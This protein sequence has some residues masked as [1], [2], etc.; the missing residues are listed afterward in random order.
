MIIKRQQRPHTFLPRTGQDCLGDDISSESTSSDDEDDDDSLIWSSDASSYGGYSSGDATSED[1]QPHVRNIINRGCKD[2]RE[3][4]DSFRA[5]QANRELH[6]N[7]SAAPPSRFWE[8]LSTLF[9]RQDTSQPAEGSIGTHAN[10][11][12]R[13]D[14]TD[15]RE[16]SDS[17]QHRELQKQSDVENLETSSKTAIGI[18]TDTLQQAREHVDKY[19]KDIIWEDRKDTSEELDSFPDPPAECEYQ[20]QSAEGN[21]D[22]SSKMDIDII[23]EK[24]QETKKRI[25]TSSKSALDVISERLQRTRE[26]LMKLRAS[27]QEAEK[28]WHQNKKPTTSQISQ[29]T[30]ATFT[31][32]IKGSESTTSS[33]RNVQSPISSK[34]PEILQRTR[35]RLMQVRASR[36]KIENQR[37]KNR[38]G[39][40]QQQ[41]Q[42]EPFDEVLLETTNASEGMMA[43]ELNM[44]NRKKLPRKNA[45]I[46]RGLKTERVRQIHDRLNQIREERAM[47]ETKRTADQE[48]LKK[49]TIESEARKNEDT[50]RQIQERLQRL[51]EQRDKAEVERRNRPKAAEGKLGRI[52]C[53]RDEVVLFTSS[54]GYTQKCN[55]TDTVIIERAVDAAEKRDQVTKKLR[56]AEERLRFLQSDQFQ[57]TMLQIRSNQSRET[58]SFY[59]NDSQPSLCE[60]H[61]ITVRRR[62]TAQVL[63]TLRTE[64][65]ALYDI[66]H[67]IS[68]EEMI[69]PNGGISGSAR[70][71]ARNQVGK[72]YL[73]VMRIDATGMVNC[74]T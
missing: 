63:E 71:Q 44:Q 1:E 18:I 65:I 54:G 24:L 51:R 29:K 21:F 72:K 41:K 40:F 62:R 57:T 68:E 16:E 49:Q 5:P 26:K 50:V 8:H 45:E 2:R 42:L 27:R 11:G 19:T 13:G 60:E 70:N 48:E 6:N 33:K 31:E 37:Q 52:R 64:P 38:I 66:D 14:C 4:R 12:F 23:S 25:E 15:T 61:T 10:D 67:T 28:Q 20:T 74:I 17:L 46:P 69:T 32:A 7:Q 56:G 9:F 53:A 35:E 59:G 73:K 36:Q 30:G 55:S 22:T 39:N 43:S 3:D 47:V 58:E 34:L